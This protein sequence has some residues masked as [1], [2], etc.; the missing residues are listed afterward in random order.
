[1]S[2]HG[3]PPAESVESPNRARH[4]A[5]IAPGLSDLLDYRFSDDFRHDA[6]A[7][8]S[9]AAV[10]LPV[11]IAYAQLAGFDPVVGLYSSI[12]PLVAYAIFGTS[13]QLM[14]NPD[15]AACAMIAAAIAPLAG[16]SAEL[17][18]SLT[19]ALTLL[20]GLFCIVASYFRLGALAD[21]LS[22]PILVGF[23]NGI[24]IS[25]FLGQ[26][27]K[28]LGFPVESSGIVPRLLEVL[29]KITLIHG[30]TLMVGLGSFAVLFACLRWLPRLPAAL[31]VLVVG[32]AA[33]AVLKLDAQGVAV[34]GRVPA[35]LPQLRWPAVPLQDVASLAA[36]AAGLALVVFTS[37]TLTARSFAAKGGYRIDVDREFAAFG[38]ANISSALSQGFVVTGADSRTAVGVAAGGRTQVTGLVAAITIAVVLLFLTEPLRYVPVAG[39]GAVLIFAA[40]SLFDVGTLREIWK[41]DRL[42]VGLSL[43]TTLGVV[44]VGAINGILIAVALALA[45]F[46]RQTA[47]P[48]DEVLGKVDGLPGF[49][50][51]ERHGRA[52]KTFP[53]LVMFRFNGPLT[54]FNCDYFKQRALA[55]A[56]AAGKDIRWFVIDAIPISDIDMNGLYALRDLNVALEARGTTL[57]FAGRRTEFLIWLQEIGLYRTELDNRLFPTLTQALKAYRRETTRAI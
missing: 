19:I 1:L 29:G 37:G 2:G 32:G 47:R 28:L 54:F 43:I 7:G 33:T 5:R 23:L 26:M 18:L 34:L 15:A 35:G 10:A 57:I 53:G 22:K 27:G 40:F 51:I 25:I 8:L 24:A 44:A 38:A 16:N 9:V 12:L 3:S 41:Y 11:S 48:R 55:A 49:H 31:A 21:F 50:S 45:R 46:V 20:T 30:P 17:Y 36:A 42:E 13:R 14:V 39:L 56:D 52:A 4:L 6:M